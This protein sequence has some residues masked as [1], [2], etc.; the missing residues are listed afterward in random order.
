MSGVYELDVAPEIS[1]PPLLVLL[2]LLYHWYP[3]ME[4]VPAVAVTDSAVGEPFKHKFCA[5]VPGFAVNVGEMH[6]YL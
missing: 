3:E 6:A 1:V 2:A 5:V 4:P